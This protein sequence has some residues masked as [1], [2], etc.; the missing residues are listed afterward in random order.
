MLGNN[1]IQA[2]SSWLR[3]CTLVLG[4][5]FEILQVQ[6]FF[7]YWNRCCYADDA[8]QSCTKRLHVSFTS[9]FAKLLNFVLEIR[10]TMRGYC[11]RLNA[12]EAEFKLSELFNLSSSTTCSD[13]TLNMTQMENTT[14][15]FETVKTWP[16]LHTVTCCNIDNYTVNCSIW[17]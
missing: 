14:K 17:I 13:I 8:N 10:A 4:D 12:Y 6:F 3:H 11:A 16:V 2:E 9:A 15:L 5:T 1:F 7:G